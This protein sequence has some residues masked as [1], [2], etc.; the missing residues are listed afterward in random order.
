MCY[1][2]ACTTLARSEERLLVDNAHL[3]AV[4]HEG[5]GEYETGG[6]CASLQHLYELLEH[7]FDKR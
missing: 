4:L 6:P 2:N 1:L 5:E 3:D 7:H